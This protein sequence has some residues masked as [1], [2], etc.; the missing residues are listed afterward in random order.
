MRTR[1]RRCLAG[2]VAEIARQDAVL[3][4]AGDAGASTS[5][6]LFI[7][8]R[9]RCRAPSPS[10]KAT[11]RPPRHARVRV[12]DGGGEGD[13]RLEVRAAP[14]RG[15]STC[16]RAPGG[17]SVTHLL[18]TT[19]HLRVE[20]RKFC[21]TDIRRASSTAL[22]PRLGRSRADEL[23]DANSGRDRPRL[24]C[25]TSQVARFHEKVQPPAKTSGCAVE[26]LERLGDRSTRV[27]N[28]PARSGARHG[29]FRCRAA[30]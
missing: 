18:V 20:G 23:V 17:R 24:S 19:F 9:R 6:R 26:S 1:R 10:S 30:S 16:R 29:W 21:V 27:P 15:R 3:D 12:D 14:Q 2:L 4:D 28:R 25:Q 8:C 7:M 22:V 13:C 11:R 5:V